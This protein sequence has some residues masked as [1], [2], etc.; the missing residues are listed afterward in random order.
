MSK[1]MICLRLKRGLRA[2]CLLLFESEEAPEP[3]VVLLRIFLFAD[4][5]EEG[6]REAVFEVL[7]AAPDDELPL[8][9]LAMT[10]GRCGSWGVALEE[11]EVAAETS[12]EPVSR[13]F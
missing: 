9:G 6:F 3:D 1:R 13:F 11:L 8:T 12:D 2:G 5:L 7:P 4:F 10:T